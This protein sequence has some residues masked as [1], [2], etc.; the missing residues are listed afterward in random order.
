[1]AIIKNFKIE[2]ARVGTIRV[3]VSGITDW[4][5]LVSKL[6]AGNNFEET[7]PEMALDGS[8]DP[9]ADTITFFLDFE[10]TDALIVDD[11]L[12]YEV[13][14]YNADKSVL[15]NCTMGSI[16]VNPVVKIDPT[17]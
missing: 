4:T 6:F 15:A 1:M 5:G 8:I 10:D 17:V 14:I 2:K 16:T 12:N 13:V 3:T 9:A 11:V 7:D